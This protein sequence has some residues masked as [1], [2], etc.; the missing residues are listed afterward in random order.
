VSL[1]LKIAYYALVMDLMVIAAHCGVADSHSHWETLWFRRLFV[2]L[3]V[4]FSL[5]SILVPV[6]SVLQFKQWCDFKFWSARGACYV[7]LWPPLPARSCTKFCLFWF[8]WYV[9]AAEAQT[10]PNDLHLFLWREKLQN[11]PLLWTAL[12][13]RPV[14]LQP[15]EL[16]GMQGW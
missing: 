7:R 9:Q 10:G 11:R 14:C 4:V 13:L 16:Q 6:F 12:Y 3:F 8:D 1:Y 15:H 5:V 2:C